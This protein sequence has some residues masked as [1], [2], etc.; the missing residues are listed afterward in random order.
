MTAQTIAKP[1]VALSDWEAAMAQLHDKTDLYERFKRD[2]ADP[3]VERDRAF[4][5]RHG[6]EFD[7]P[8]YFHRRIALQAEQG[9]QSPPSIADTADRL[10]DAM[11]DAEGDLMDTPAPD[12]AALLFK[13]EKLLAVENGG[14][15][16]W[17]AAYV[18]QTVED[19]RRLLK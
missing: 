9:Y 6:L 3:A 13:L 2:V 18:A 14:T 15:D 12:H 1:I 10:C 11:T 5:R 7:A 16:A 8:D 19:M 17:S 4:E